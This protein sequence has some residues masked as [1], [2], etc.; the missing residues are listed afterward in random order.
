MRPRKPA[1]GPTL[2][3]R[4]APTRLAPG[5]SLLGLAAAG[6]AALFLLAPPRP[7][8]GL[9]E[10]PSG[11]GSQDAPSGQEDAKLD[12]R[13]KSP[14]ALLR[15]G[16]YE[17]AEVAFQK[18]LEEAFQPTALRGV[19]EAQVAVGKADS[20]LKL[21]EERPEARSSSALLS[22]KGRVLL[23]LGR[24]P[25]AEQAFRSAL[26][27]DPGN[28]EAVNRLGEALS[29]QGKTAEATERWG[30]IVELYQEMSFEDVEKAP[31]EVFVE[32]GLALVGLNRFKEAYDVMFST[33]RDKDAHHPGLLLEAGR[34]LKDKYNFPDSRAELREALADNGRFADALVVLAD[35]YLSDFQVG[36]TRYELAEKALSKAL[37]VNPFHAEAYLVR[38][39]L[40][41]S[42][43]Q[44][45]KAVTSL[46]RS[47]ELDPSSLRARGLLA[48][49]HFL[50]ADEAA[51][52]AAE[53]AALAVNPK[54]AEFYATIATT[55]ESKFRYKEAVQFCDRALAVD[56]EYWPAYYTLA[57]NCLRTGE[58]ERGR[59]YLQK[60]WD[61]DRFNVWVFNT[62]ALLRHM[63]S[64]YQE[65]K[66]DAFVFKFPRP[67]FDVL[68]TYMVPLLEDAVVKLS[69]HYKTP[70]PRPVYVEAF[71]EH[72]W[73]SARTVGLEG[74]AAAGACFGQV[75]TLTT[76]RALPQNWGAV[77][78][79]E[80][81]HVVALALTRNRVPRWFTEGLSVFEEGRDHPRWARVFEREIADTY[82][83]G[84]LL[85]MAELDFG[86]SKPKYPNQILI[87]Y[88]QGCLI[89]QHIKAKHGFDKVLEML[90]GYGADKSTPQIFQEVLGQSLEE[91]DREFFA[92]VAQWIQD[93]GYEPAVAEEHLPVLEAAV[94]EEPRS[95]DKLVQLAWGYLS[96]GNEVDAP[97]TAQ[98]ILELD[99]ANGDAQ[100]ILGLDALRR[101]NQT[102]A[103]ESLE[104][105][106]A[107][108]TRFRFRT[109]SALGQIAKSSG[110]SK[111]AIERFE[112]AKKVSPRAG[113]AYPPGRNLY[114]DL[115]ALYTA[116][117]DEDA[118][119][120]Q[121]EE[122]SQCAPE[123]PQCRQRIAVHYLKKGGVEAARKAVAALDEL[124]YINPFSP[125]THQSL[126]RAA[127]E[128][129]D[130]D[131]TIREYGYLLK[132]PDTNPKVAHLALAKAYAAKKDASRAEKSAR[133]VLLIDPGNEE[134][135]AI[136]DALAAER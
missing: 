69:A 128:A 77:A 110:D 65:L 121:M 47:I 30:T 2:L 70:I 21:L 89:V 71:S 34:V 82:A 133:E 5:P 104:K 97:L 91:F 28:V 74:F 80:F 11:A 4:A 73:F 75:V 42:D 129:E 117:G 101:K 79:H 51:V 63:D 135:K 53:A 119:V 100:A 108:G 127:V 120:R 32:M 131:I 57:N 56:P 48:A 54:G 102:L 134:A 115:A 37:E 7:L 84:R 114:Y 109:L 29:R 68:S 81:A 26:E 25:D 23:R 46:E 67:D 111:L 49:C 61:H 58:M 1:T 86:F 125:E 99:P 10:E 88:F 20:A 50:R 126:A 39:V 16:E 105:A 35:N 95:V 55:I 122:L 106:L 44:M 103:K 116:S 76:P 59:E 18:Q 136:L 107:G 60:S 83:S 15:R 64:H 98:K 8:L 24:L 85:G 52:K 14:K 130:P 113:A 96:T 38:G 124:L 6:F 72:K 87:S 13:D 31:P 3:D 22:A 92:Y 41:L 123:D 36:T 27:L 62:R 45:G 90:A 43:G 93:N 17:E 12:D 94:E 9:E 40:E 33:A 19:V 78:W 118:A 66:T 132:L 112:A